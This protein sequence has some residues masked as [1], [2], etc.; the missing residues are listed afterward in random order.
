MTC[1]LQVQDDF[2]DCYA[3]PSVIGKIGTDIQDR[4]CSWLICQAL[5]MSTEDQRLCIM[6]R[7]R[8]GPPEYLAIQ[9]LCVAPEIWELYIRL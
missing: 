4:K 5:K 8:V 7:N 3:D 2:L 9:D 6:V 1:L